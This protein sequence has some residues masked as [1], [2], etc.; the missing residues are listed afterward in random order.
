MGPVINLKAVKTNHSN[1]NFRKIDSKFIPLTPF[2][3]IESPY[4]NS[5]AFMEAFHAD[6]DKK[7]LR[8]GKEKIGN[9]LGHFKNEEVIIMSKNAFKILQ[10]R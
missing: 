5:N 9:F 10:V 6:S 4:F 3:H 7:F 8:E 2:L 1:V